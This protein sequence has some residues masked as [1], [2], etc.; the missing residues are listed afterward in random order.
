MNTIAYYLIGVGFL[1]FFV[2]LPSLWD[3][4]TKSCPNYNPYE[5]CKYCAFDL[6]L[7]KCFLVISLVC[8]IVSELCLKG[9]ISL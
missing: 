5:S 6:K 3:G 9:Y 1:L 7:A 4:L 2:A 8:F